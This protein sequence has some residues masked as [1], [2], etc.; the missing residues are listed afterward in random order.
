MAPSQLLAECPA[1]P[2]LLCAHAKVFTDGQIP[3][4]SKQGYGD[5][6]RPCGFAPACLRTE[7]GLKPLSFVT[8]PPFCG[9]PHEAAAEID[10][11]AI[12]KASFSMAC[13]E[14]MGVM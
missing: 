6:Q 8:D 14:Q 12:S 1:F 10:K 11:C 13:L 3:A 5:F 2:T 4:W 7:F 9:L